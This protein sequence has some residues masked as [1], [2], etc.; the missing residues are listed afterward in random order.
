MT[1]RLTRTTTV[2]AIL[3]L[4][5]FM[6]TQ[7]P[8]ISLA[9]GAL[10][11]V[12]CRVETDRS[13]LPADDPQNVILKIT[14]DAPKVPENTARPRVNIALV[15]DRSGS[16]GGTKI[17]MAKAAAM[18]ALSRLGTDDVFSLVTYATDVTTLVPARKVRETGAII[19]A[20]KGIEAG[21]NTALFGG[22]SQG[23]AQIRKHVEDDYIHRVVLLSDGLANVGPRN[24]VDLGRLGA[25]LFKENISVTTVGVGMDYNEDLMAQL[26]QKSDG[27]TYF[28]ESGTDL[29]RIFAAELGNVLNVVAKQVVVT[30]T[31]PSGIEPVGIIGREGRIRNNRIELSMNQLYGGQKKF[32]LV[33]VRM[34]GQKEG[35]SVEIAKADV[36]Y[37][38]PF[39]M[40]SLNTQAKA[41]A[42]FSRNKAKVAA[43]TNAQVVKDYQLNLNALAQEKAIELSDQGKTKEAARELRQSAA[44]LKGYAG[45]YNDTQALEEAREAEAQADVLETQGMSKK[46]RKALRTKSYQMKNQ[47]IQK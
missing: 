24:P 35:S 27:N 46:S 15:M 23:A 3:I 16:M 22:V 43:S 5:I 19:N 4:S 26:A 17:K 39:S 12:T 29:P 7:L 32:A 25:G 44:A 31:L 21:G 2:A 42:R 45:K 10:D 1:P 28:A 11:R 34:K 47:Q 20:I 9:T 41:T 33:E 18:E 8:G 6:V 40:E 30:I 38:D 14:L 13:V 37:Q 36:S